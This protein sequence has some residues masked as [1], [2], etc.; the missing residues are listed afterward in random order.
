LDKDG[1]TWKALSKGGILE[2]RHS[3]SSECVISISAAK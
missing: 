3:K 2:L 1:W